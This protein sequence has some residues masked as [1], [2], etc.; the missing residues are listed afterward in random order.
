MSKKDKKKKKKSSS[1]F[2]SDG[3]IKEEETFPEQFTSVFQQILADKCPTDSVSGKPPEAAPSDVTRCYSYSDIFLAHARL[4]VFADCYQIDS[5][6]DQALR[7]LHQALTTNKVQH[8]DVVDVTE[9][10]V[11]TEIPQTLREVML[12]Y[13]TSKASSA[14]GIERFRKLVLQDNDMMAELLDLIMKATMVE[15]P[16]VPGPF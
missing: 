12:A 6:A 5:L 7:N 1:F 3:V 13:I 9:F 15:Q 11:S 14:W 16:T 4:F 8:S 2:G 10:C